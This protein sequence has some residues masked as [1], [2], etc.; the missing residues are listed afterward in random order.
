MAGHS[1][2]K[3]IMYRKGAQDKKRGKIFTKLGKEIVVAVKTSGADP[4]SNPRLRA[5]LAEARA[6]N[7]P[8]DNI[9]RAIKK[10]TG[11]DA[12]ENYEEVRYE[13]Y[14]HGGVGII[15]EALTDNRNRTAPEVR[16]AF[17]KYGGSLGETGSL[18]FIFDRLGVITYNAQDIN[19]EQFFEQA[20]DA[21]AQDIKE[22]DNHINV[23]TTIEGLHGVLKNLTEASKLQPVTFNLQWL[24]KITINIEDENIANNVIKLINALEDIDDVQKV[25]ANFDIAENILEKLAV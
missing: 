1:Q 18:S 19:L 23:I 21:G 5:A 4:D 6:N 3:N 7:M 20:I 22:E 14:A 10:A 8:K 24:P 25:F 9:D 12:T 17:T 11:S 13:G 15:I 2:F 16:A